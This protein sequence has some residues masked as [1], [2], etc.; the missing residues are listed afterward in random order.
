MRKCR[1]L[2][3][4]LVRILGLILLLKKKIPQEP[5]LPP[6]ASVLPLVVNVAPP[7]AQPPTTAQDSMLLLWEESCSSLADHSCTCPRL[8]LCSGRA[9]RIRASGKRGGS[10][11][12]TSLQANASA[13]QKFQSSL[14]VQ[15]KDK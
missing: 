3:W 1:E 11:P 2:S 10:V 8:A 5:K 12:S 14:K 13:Q 7:A 4:I 6:E 15:A 9:D